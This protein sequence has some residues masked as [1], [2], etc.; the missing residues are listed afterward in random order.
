MLPSFDLMK[1]PAG[2]ALFLDIDGTL[3]EI[4]DT[5]DAVVVPQ[6]LKRILREL[7]DCLDGAVALVSGRSIASID[8]LFKPLILPTSG[9]H[10]LEY[11][12]A[13]GHHS[14]DDIVVLKKIKNVQNI[15]K[16][17]VDNN[18]GTILEDKGETVALHYRLRPKAKRAAL[19]IIADLISN[20]A[21]LEL[22][23]GKMVLEIKPKVSHK[24]I[25]ILKF[26][27][28]CPFLGKM[29][30]FIGDDTSDE[31]GFKAVN[32]RGGISISVDTPYNSE[33]R[34]QLN[35]VSEVQNWLENLI[36]H[37]KKEKYE[38]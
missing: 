16:K 7:Q 20:H 28:E 2:V 4:A 29:P 1:F 34:W 31:D 10:G 8:E 38:F 26:M 21:D 11:R 19:T 32:E 3:I 5:P 22:I 18:P 12:D 24:G 14:K 25:A 9:K 27:N 6:K 36:K 13:L 15:L 23:T 30:I 35:S 37:L 33:A 17:F